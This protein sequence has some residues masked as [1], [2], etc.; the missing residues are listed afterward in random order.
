[1]KNIFKFL[2][3]SIIGTYNWPLDL[4]ERLMM[5]FNRWSVLLRRGC[6]VGWERT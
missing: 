3:W 4:K 1:M 6:M 5:E 2:W